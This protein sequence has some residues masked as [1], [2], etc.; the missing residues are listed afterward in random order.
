MNMLQGKR[1]YELSKNNENKE[2]NETHLGYIQSVISR[3]AQNSF[4]AK[5]WGITVI[6]ALITFCLSKDAYDLRSY[7]IMI[8]CVV[9]CLFCFVDTYYLY[10]ERG[11]REL[12]NIVAGINESDKV[13]KQYDLSIPNEYRSWKNRKKA[14][15]SWSTGGFYSI[16]IILLIILKVTLK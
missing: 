1:R 6:T 10:L 2:P 8:A 7:S 12:Y 9:V 4:H 11:Y 13:I 15:F 14:L 16:V 5:T 3:M